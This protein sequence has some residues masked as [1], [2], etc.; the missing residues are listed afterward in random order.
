[1]LPE[2]G[3]PEGV[4]GQGAQSDL[5]FAVHDSCST[6][7]KTEIHDGIRWIMGEL[8]YATEEPEYTREKTRCCGFG[9]MVVPANPELAL[10]VMRRRT[11]EVESDHM[12]TYCA[13][14]RESMVKGGKEA[15]HILD[16]IYEPTKSKETEFVGVGG[17]P[18]KAWGNR[19]K[20]K[21]ELER[22]GASHKKAYRRMVSN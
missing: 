20:A 4:N 3:L 19:F 21:R 1:V 8:D 10:R 7:D 16:L 6:R 22:A 18:L 12:V 9:G 15:A 5:T 17:G 2:I 11:A 14:C 13:A